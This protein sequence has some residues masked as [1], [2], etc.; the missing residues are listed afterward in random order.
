MARAGQDQPPLPPDSGKHE[1]PRIGAVLLELR[2][3][4][5]RAERCRRFLEQQDFS[6]E[7]WMEIVSDVDS[8]L[9]FMVRPQILD[10][11]VKH[12]KNAGQP[13]RRRVLVRDLAVL[14]VS[15][16]ERV[17]QAITTSLRSRKLALFPNNSIG[18]PEW[19]RI[20]SE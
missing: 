16:L 19:K 17:Q 1:P 10:A 11:I 18:L 4:L 3:A 8:D 12:L 13:V 5:M 2:N 15:T 7:R 9:R 20:E 14:K 6:Q